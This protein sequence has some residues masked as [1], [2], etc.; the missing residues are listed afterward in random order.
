M[1]R[2]AN[3]FAR[4]DSILS[5]RTASLLTERSRVPETFRTRA[6]HILLV[7]N[8]PKYAIQ[9]MNNL[10]NWR[11]DLTD[12]PCT[13][14]IAPDIECAREHLRQ[15]KVDVF[16]LDLIM[17]ES[18]DAADEDKKIGQAFAREVW[19]KTNAGIIVHTTLSEDDADSSTMLS[20]GADDYIR[21]G[22][23]DLKTI[24]ARIQ[25]LWRRIQLIR[26][27]EKDSYGHA[28]R[29]FLIGSWKFIAGSRS[30]TN[31]NGET[32]KLSPTEHAFLRH[33]CT[34]ENN[35]CDKASFNLSVLG[36]RSFEDNM[37][38]DNFVYRL[39]KKL[40]ENLQLLADQG[41][42]RLVGVKEVKPA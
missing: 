37:R 34:S 22:A 4:E 16:I 12:A 28:N 30:L 11:L 23:T 13:I 10:K 41:T 20:E 35:E 6:P 1:I 39:R 5:P 18:C 21:K 14:D 17:N 27:T 7:E 33:L 38:V 3:R 32:L 24:R 36:R 25:A 31:E 9:L 42:Y 15:D 19:E 2:L 26:P 40:G 8:D 29:V